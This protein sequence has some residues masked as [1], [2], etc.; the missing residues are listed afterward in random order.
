MGGN[1]DRHLVVCC[2]ND[3]DCHTAAHRQP[4]HSNTVAA[5]GAPAQQHCNTS[6]CAAVHR[7]TQGHTPANTLAHDAHQRVPHTTAPRKPTKV[8][9]KLLPSHTATPRGAQ[10][11]TGTHRD[12]P[13]NTLVHIRGCPPHTTASRHAK[14]NEIAHKAPAITQ[15][16]CS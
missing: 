10:G 14:T 5:Q 16:S 8:L 11:H 7:D 9:T 2:N 6:W 4:A 15:Y 1:D 3:D 12:T 13:A